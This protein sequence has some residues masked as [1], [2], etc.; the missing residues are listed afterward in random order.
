MKLAGIG[1][2]Q[3]MN[4]G[5]CIIITAGL[6]GAFACSGSSD[7]DSAGRD[8]GTDT[9]DASTGTTELNVDTEVVDGLNS[10]A[11]V[12]DNAVMGLNG[13]GRP[14]IAYG[15]VAANTT[16]REIYYAEQ[17][18][19]GS[20]TRS[21]VV[22]PGEAA[23]Y[24]GDPL[25]GL[26][27][28]HV[29]DVPY[30]VYL[31]GQ[32]GDVVST[33]PSDLMLS[34]RSNS[35]WSERTLADRSGEASTDC[36][37]DPR[38]DYCN[39]GRVVGSNA[40]IA[41]NPSGQGFGV[42]YRDTHNG[43]AVDDINSGDVEVY[44][45]GTVALHDAVDAFFGAGE[46][47][48]I[49]FPAATKILVAYQARAP[50]TTP[51]EQGIYAASYTGTEWVRKRLS[52]SLTESK[53]AV[54]STP[55][56]TLYVAFFHADDADLVV[57]KSTD[58][59]ES[60]TTD[61]VDFAGKTGLHPSMTVDAEGRVVIA[62]TY[63]G[64]T[65]DAS[66]PGSLGSAAEVRMV[67]LEQGTWRKYLVDDGQGFGNVGLFNSVVVLPSGKLAFSYQ[68]SSLNDLIYAEE[69]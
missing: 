68:D 63:C 46:S 61:A 25:Q 45:E 66:C 55:D 23:N 37:R 17:Q 49:V 20:W 13:A 34:T 53:I 10:Q 35:T 50:N 24:T 51:P 54:A 29:G 48:N 42:V 9:G 2:G 41:A 3:I 7:P 16:L 1:E 59:G 11:L 64:P 40:S 57:A 31:G 69:Q 52:S 30:I 56:G 36:P 32:A 5:K 19:D 15:F 4:K 28:T 58:S 14:A 26:G 60:W 67:R 43:F 22:A 62:Y 44:A 21:R 39:F 18:G 12:G 33:G 8:S 6:L 47:G 38:D 27:L 65:S